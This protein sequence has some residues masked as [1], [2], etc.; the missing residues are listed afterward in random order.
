MR[1]AIS[2]KDIPLR[3]ALTTYRSLEF[4]RLSLY[5]FLMYLPGM[6]R[7]SVIMFF[8]WLTD[9]DGQIFAKGYISLLRIPSRHSTMQ[10]IFVDIVPSEY[11]TD[12]FHRKHSDIAKTDRSW[13]VISTTIT[14]N[15]GWVSE[16]MLSRN[17][18]VSFIGITLT[19]FSGMTS[20]N[21]E[22]PEAE[23]LQGLKK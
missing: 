10:G 22:K 3:E 5:N 13:Y 2:L 9:C 15:C 1:T 14:D 20:I 4:R 23:Y 19:D 6:V 12:R 11:K 7:T 8:S 21:A 18:R 16:F 17:S